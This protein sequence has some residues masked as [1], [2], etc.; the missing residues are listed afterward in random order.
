M[1]AVLKC[2]RQ[3]SPAVRRLCLAYIFIPQPRPTSKTLNFLQI[4]Y[5]SLSYPHCHSANSLSSLESMASRQLPACD[6]L[7]YSL[8][9]TTCTPL[10][11]KSVMNATKKG[12][13]ILKH[14][15]DTHMVEHGGIEYKA[16]TCI[17]ISDYSR[18]DGNYITFKSG[19]EA[20]SCF[21][22]DATL[23][24]RYLAVS[25]SV[26]ASYGLKKS[27]KREDQFAFYSLNA[28]T[29]LAEMMDYADLLDE[30]AL[31]KR[32][33]DL[34]K[35]F[36]GQD[37]KNLGEWKGFFAS[38][39]SH[40]IL[41]A[42][43]GAAFQLSVWASNAS[44]S[45]NQNFSASVTATFEG[46]TAGGKFDASVTK[47]DQYKSF[48]ESMQ[49]TVSVV[50]GNPKLNTTLTADPTHHDL[51]NKWVNSI[52][53]DSALVNFSVVEIWNLMKDAGKRELRG[54]SSMVQE[55][56]EYIVENPRPYKTEVSFD[57]QS[58][59]AEF[60]LLSPSGIIALEKDYQPPQ[61]T[62]VFSGTRV[63]WG[64]DIHEFKK[65]T[66][67]F[68][69][70]NDGSPIDFSV[71]HGSH[72]SEPGKGRAEVIM[73]TKNY[74]SEGITDN[75][76]NTTWFYQKPVSS[77]PATRIA[78]R[79]A[80]KT[81]VPRSWNDVLNEYIEEIGAHTAPQVASA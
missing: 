61:Y 30:D 38:F 36:S 63:S 81:D 26:S 58:D 34:P 6:W 59:W 35:P 46:I 32:L 80:L 15:T 41:K 54:L 79:I 23:S 42:S 20:Y 78:T 56:Y 1:S 68:F 17:G 75:N 9:M 19:T 74:V 37:E 64:K 69:I 5:N 47:E 43:Y 4:N 45:V 29:Y 60:N 65:Q 44:S 21:E 14:T 22:G 77:T 72:G 12:R 76:W 51:Y 25:A 66:I 50:G 3:A 33:D 2:L 48:S 7:G 71:S 73:A 67:R 52:T 49:K 18:S 39:G 28:D 62:D 11:M 55:A 31:T 70:V 57:I 16:P 40:V 27:L 24:G 8:D 53:E 10:D 13:R